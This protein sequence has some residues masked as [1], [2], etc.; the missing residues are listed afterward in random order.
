MFNFSKTLISFN[1]RCNLKTC[2]QIAS[3][4]TELHSNQNKQQQKGKYVLGWVTFHI[5]HMQVAPLP[6]IKRRESYT[7]NTSSWEITISSLLLLQKHGLQSFSFGKILCS[8]LWGYSPYSDCQTSKIYTFIHTW[9]KAVHHSITTILWH[10]F[11]TQ[12]R[13]NKKKKPCL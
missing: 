12:I 11:V 10:N 7:T 1:Q 8:L 4:T 2:P 5:Q 3:S 9:V 13:R 6:S